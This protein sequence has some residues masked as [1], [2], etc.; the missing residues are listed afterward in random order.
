MPSRIRT[1]FSANSTSS[2][3]KA[4]FNRLPSMSSLAAAATHPRKRASCS[5]ASWRPHSLSIPPLAGSPTSLPVN[6]GIEPDR[7]PSR[8]YWKRCRNISSTSAAELGRRFHHGPQVNVNFARHACG[9]FGISFCVTPP[10]FRASITKWKLVF[11]LLVRA[12]AVATVCRHT[13]V[14]GV[15]EIS[16]SGV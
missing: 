1:S 11:R 3:S 9:Q 14:S 5:L 8:T 4:S 13:A 10:S 12:S 16:R 6:L 2:A 7:R 15:P